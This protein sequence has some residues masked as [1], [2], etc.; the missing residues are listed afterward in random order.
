MPRKKL[1]ILPDRKNAHVDCFA[2]YLDTA[3]APACR[4]LADVYCLKQRAPCP[5]CATPAEAAAARKKAKR[6]LVRIG[7]I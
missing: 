6:R 2:F 3:G 4:A 5:F 7:R 1:T